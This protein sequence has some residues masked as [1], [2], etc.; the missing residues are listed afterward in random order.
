M[1]RFCLKVFE[2]LS[3]LALIAIGGSSYVHAANPPTVKILKGSGI[4]P[5][6]AITELGSAT[7]HSYSVVNDT[8]QEIVDL[9]AS[10]KNDPDLIFEYVYDNVETLPLYGLKNG[11]L[12]A[13][14]DGKGTA[15]DQAHLLVE[16]LR[17]AGY[18]AQ[19]R[20]GTATLSGAQFSNLFGTTSD[21][22][23]CELLRAGGFGMSVNG[24]TSCSSLSSSTASSDVEFVHVWVEVYIDDGYYYFDPSIKTQTRISGWTLSSQ[25][26]YNGSTFWTNADV[27]ANT[28]GSGAT[29]YSY[30][31]TADSAQIETDLASYADT[32]V[33]NMQSEANHDLS[34]TDIAGGYEIEPVTI[35][36]GGLRQTEAQLGHTVSSNPDTWTGDIP[37]Q[38]RTKVTISYNNVDIPLYADDLYG[39]RMWF[40]KR[41][42]AGEPVI[43]F[44]IGIHS[45]VAF[46][47]QTSTAL[48]VSIDHPYA[49]G[50]NS[51]GNHTETL[52][53]LVGADAEAGLVL[54]FGYIGMGLQGRYQNLDWQ[55]LTPPF[56]P[57]VAEKENAMSLTSIAAS[58]MAQASYLMTLN[59]GVNDLYSVVHDHVGL[60]SSENDT[61]GLIQPVMDIRSQISVT[62]PTHVAANRTAALQTVTSAL[63]MLEGA[64]LDQVADS[65]ATAPDSVGTTTLFSE[66]NDDSVRFYDV[67]SGNWSTV[68]SYIS[69]YSS[70][71]IADITSFLSGS[72]R[73][74]LPDDGS[75]VKGDFTGMAYIY[76]DSDDAIGHN[77]DD[78]V[79]TPNSHLK[80]YIEQ[81]DVEPEFVAK[82]TGVT[83][84]SAGSNSQVNPA[85][86]AARS[87]STDLVTG[88]G[89]FPFSLPFTRSFRADANDGT[90]GGWTHNYA[91]TG[92]LTSDGTLAL[93][94]RHAVEAARA[95][96]A[97]YVGRE[98]LKSGN[99]IERVLVNTII[100]NWLH[101]GLYNNVF[102]LRQAHNVA[103]FVRLADGSWS[104]P[105]GLSSSLT[106]S[107]SGASTSVIYTAK[108]GVEMAFAATDA[109]ARE[110]R[111]STQSWPAGM[112]MTLTYPSATQIVA[113][114]GL[115]RT[116]TIDIDSEGRMTKVEDN[117]GRY[118]DY[119]YTGADLVSAD[120]YE[121]I[122]GAST[123]LVDYTYSG[124][125]LNTI[126]TPE[127]TNSVTYTHNALKQ[128]TAITTPERGT[129]YVYENNWR[130]ELVDPSGASVV[131]IR[132]PYGRWVKTVNGT[133][134][135]TVT[136]LDR[137]GRTVNVEAPEGNSADYE[138]DRYH[139][140][141]S[142]TVN[143]KPASGLSSKT[144]SYTYEGAAKF[145]QLSTVTD[146]GS[147]VTTFAYETT[148]GLLSSVTRPAVSV[149]GGASQNPVTSYSYNANGQPLTI[150]APDG[151]VTRFTYNAKG[152]VTK[153]EADDGGLNINT[154]YGYNAV[155]DLTTVTD[156]R[157]K[158]TTFSYDYLRRQTG[159]TGP[160]SQQAAYV[161]DDAGR[162]EQSKQLINS[163]W[164]ITTRAYDDDNRVISITDNG[165]NTTS[166]TYDDV[167]R[168]VT[169][170]DPDS[171]TVKTLYDEAGRKIEMVRG[172][173]TASESHDYITYNDN[174]T[175][176]TLKDGKNN[177]T[178]YS[179]DG[180]DR[181]VATNYPLS[182]SSTV[183]AFDDLG[184]PT[185]VTTRKGDT[186]TMSYDALGRLDS[187]TVPGVGTYSYDY[188]I[189]GQV[190]TA[191]LGAQTV[192][193]AYDALGRVTQEVGSLGRQMDYVYDDAAGTWDVKY[194]FPGTESDYWLRYA[195]DDAGRLDTIKESGSTTIADYAYD[196]GSR[197]TS[198]TFGN[199]TTESYTYDDVGYVETITQNFTGI[200]D[201]SV[202][203]Y[204]RNDT[205][206]IT[207]QSISNP[208][209]R[210]IP[211]FLE[212]E[213]LSYSSNGLNQY[214]SIA[215]TTQGHDANGNLTQD[216]VQTFVF[217]AAG[218][219]TEAKS[220]GVTVGTY[221]YDPLGRRSEKTA[222]GIN[223]EFLWSG[224]QVMADYDGDTGNLMRRY[225]YG[226][227][228]DDLVA[229][230]DSS[231]NK[232]YVHK[233][234][235]GSVV[236]VS[237]NNGDVVDKFT[238]GP[239]GEG[240]S[241]AESPYKYT[242]RR[243]DQE[244]GLYYYRNRYYNAQT[245]RFISPDPLGYV[246]GMNMY[247]YVGN[248]P[249]NY[250][251][252]MGLCSE[253]EGWADCTGTTGSFH[254]WGMDPWLF[255]MIHSFVPPFANRFADTPGRPAGGG[256]SG[257][258]SNKNR[259]NKDPDA[260][261]CGEDYLGEVKENWSQEQMEIHNLVF[262]RLRDVNPRSISL[263]SEMTFGVYSSW[264]SFGPQLTEE[265][266]GKAASA[267]I[268]LVTDQ[269][270]TWHSLI[271]LVHTHAQFTTRY[272]ENEFSP[273]DL[274]IGRSMDIPMYL[275]TPSG[276]FLVFNPDN[277]KIYDLTSNLGCLPT[278]KQ[279]S[280]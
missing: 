119:G 255:E 63:A 97:L 66:A 28:V 125:T 237:D 44:R 216:G 76:I 206:Q 16:M 118:V 6:D 212:S 17:A 107:G 43:S 59:D 235:S 142:V 89:A 196:S 116:L 117:T 53:P 148:T 180:F 167:N 22:S 62:D 277:G 267:S 21:R 87:S 104:T 160:L 46:T 258:G 240:A 111:L 201:D 146:P 109:T 152:E 245:G 108:S 209:F 165:S 153:S 217:N 67:T 225:V 147:N 274:K 228:I 280:E 64:T 69:N 244:S 185:S 218:Q 265:R 270:W 52:N 186:I 158:V 48:L 24:T 50:G 230:V 190:T 176:A 259:G 74:V 130:T 58:W 126:S 77:M 163:V 88:N 144:T 25:M 223:T 161:Y 65:T 73:I 90:K 7:A 234:A 18:A 93:G 99:S 224:S 27:S 215:G 71:E 266:V 151:T 36:S 243:V 271:A 239:F 279:G 85:N 264:F 105:A 113:S 204:T 134:D 192:T 103:E 91:V 257:S 47:Y 11:A 248:D 199:G 133:G 195:V 175:I 60:V 20:F 23:A 135:V 140:V 32:L 98:V 166:I 194:N 211:S 238:Y 45:R 261:T 72:R 145:R 96:V 184:R 83:G 2:F 26:G 220:G 182:V 231:D 29:A 41:E 187:R 164:H 221:A 138:Y 106:F 57:E 253:D 263:Q 256:G 207:N 143:P 275:G 55:S 226:L 278:E 183:N 141:S 202:W 128:A 102:K 155:G 49:E 127:V 272:I 236:A 177:I 214:T 124:I 13:V 70:A 122:G 193:S 35:P 100:Q 262:E 84:S 4:S 198:I 120:L 169:V 269:L 251:D 1:V 30:A 61:A 246:D 121:I 37:D 233:N 94:R 68:Q 197:V 171:R 123:S 82:T 9:A 78:G 250:R 241:E 156:H 222:G 136:T 162:L 112:T 276:H 5:S 191:Y 273:A 79:S 168:T 3:F 157:N 188:D 173:G 229:I 75:L 39:K 149:N 12:G 115:G 252:P 110:F 131:T 139:N 54:G 178:S 181:R 170:T 56:W 42:I 179:Y 19:Y 260:A 172:E 137:L 10:L 159:M 154:T 101:K 40:E 51:F 189:M 15:F 227:G 254:D 34:V 210:W 203:T 242:A 80:G 205:G 268:S 95:M 38:H 200:T 129:T 247:A 150:T 213:T 249:M 174:G 132:D 14:I 208:D 81:G 86:A 8:H 92:E 114:N 33:A 31:E 232:S 219:M